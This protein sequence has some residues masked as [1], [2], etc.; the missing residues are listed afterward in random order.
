MTKY[1]I[2]ISER[3]QNDLDSLSN[4]ISFEYKAPKTAIKYL[5]ELFAVINMLSQNADIFQFQTRKSIVDAYGTFVRRIN[6]KKMAI[7]YTIHTDTVYILRV[8]PQSTISGL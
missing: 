3:A 7:L 5:R 4:V 6:Y 8:I 1:R 2:I